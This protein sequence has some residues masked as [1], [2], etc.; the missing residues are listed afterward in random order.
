MAQ[1]YIAMLLANAWGA[2]AVPGVATA[3]V[4]QCNSASMLADV[5]RWPTWWATHEFVDLHVFGGVHPRTY[6]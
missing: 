1:R 2:F 4:R 3:A 6:V 5:P